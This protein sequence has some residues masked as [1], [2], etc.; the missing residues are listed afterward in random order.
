MNSD[1]V[2]PDSKKQHNIS[3]FL[4][5]ITIIQFW[6]IAV[7]GISYIAIDLIA[8]P[9]RIIELGLYLGMLVFITIFVYSN[10]DVVEWF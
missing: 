7:W 8:G 9:S 2:N 4:F 3:Q 1:M 6:W 5:I 10:P